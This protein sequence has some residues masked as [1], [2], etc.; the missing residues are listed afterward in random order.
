MAA[1]PAALLGSSTNQVGNEAG[2]R[3]R[4]VAMAVRS[5]QKTGKDTMKLRILARAGLICMA[6]AGAYASSTLA[7]TASESKSS[8]WLSSTVNLSAKSVRE[9]SWSD[10][11]GTPFRASRL[12]PRLLYTLYVPKDYDEY[13]DKTYWLTVVVHGTERSPAEYRDRYAKFAEEQ[14][15]IV[16]AP[17]F[18]AN[19]QDSNDLENYKLIDYRGTRYDLVLLSMIDEVAAKY[20]LRSHRFLLFGFSGGGHFA[21]RFFYLHPH[22]LLGV[23]I[24]A[25]GV[26]T[27][28]DDRN[29][30]WVGVRDVY[31]RFGVKMNLPALRRVPVQMVIGSEDKEA[32]DLPI[33]AGSPYWMGQ[34]VASADFNAAGKTRLERMV[35]LKQSFEGAGIAVRHDIVPGAAHESDALDERVQGFFRQALQRAA[36]QP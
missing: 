26:V 15:S 5:S 10:L 7:Q 11:Q 13:G 29:D 21:H 36:S 30:W 33:D 19:T 18:A 20:R 22:R 25:P 34:G 35:R 28:L 1:R 3:E 14:G 2:N 27:L 24:G 32:W 16:L 6:V 31:R 23:S 8:P 12:D 17:L 9:F 4:I